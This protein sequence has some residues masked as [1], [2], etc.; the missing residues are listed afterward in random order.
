[1]KKTVYMYVVDTMADWE[2]GYFLQGFTLQ[3]MLVKPVYRFCTVGL[4]KNAIVTAGGVTIIPDCTIDEIK[5]DEVAALLLPGA[6][7]W[8]EAAQQKIL[9]LVSDLLSNGTVVA[10]IC[11]AT[12]G[13]ANMG[14]LNSRQ[15]TSNAVCFLSQLST[16]YTGQAFY[17]DVSAVRDGNLI[18]ASSAGGLLWAR[19]ILESLDMYT[20]VTI[21]AWYSYFATGDAKC[22]GILMESFKDSSYHQESMEKNDE[23]I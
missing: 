18:T 5:K 1:M 19:Y 17:K 10:A 15:H 13:L 16:N 21:E 3:K 2:T 9:S 22:F 12:L 4:S 14:I 20:K 7:V 11:G 8:M 6:D 23:Q